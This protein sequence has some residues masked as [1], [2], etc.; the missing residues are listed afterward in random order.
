MSAL[1]KWAGR[2]WKLAVP[3]LKAMSPG[4]VLLFATSEDA[5]DLHADVIGTNAA[6]L[7]IVVDREGRVHVVDDVERE[8]GEIAFENVEALAAALT[9]QNPPRA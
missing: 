2:E 4:R 6:G 8:L 5:P 9:K 3:E 7:L 1:S